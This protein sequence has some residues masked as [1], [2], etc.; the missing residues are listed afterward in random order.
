MASGVT[1]VVNNVMLAT[2][3]GDRYITPMLSIKPLYCKYTCI[4]RL[5][6][7]IQASKALVYSTICSNIN[8]IYHVLCS[9]VLYCI[10]GG[11]GGVEGAWT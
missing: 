8:V 3:Q 11:G 5:Y 1:S 6:G 2:H 4:L 9:P 10:I 7:Q